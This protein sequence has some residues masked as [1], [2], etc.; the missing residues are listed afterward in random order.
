MT[1]HPLFLDV[2]VPMYAGGKEHPLRPACV[3]V[4]RQA[5]EGMLEVVID[6]EIVQEILH[7]YGAIGEGDIGVKMAR[8]LLDIVP[9]IYAITI[10]DIRLTIEIFEKYVGQGITARDAI[11][12]A[13]MVNNGSTH[14]LSADEH[15]DCVEGI[16]R[17]RVES[18]E[19]T[20]R[21][22]ERLRT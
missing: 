15:F 14:I 10:Q 12:A 7:R 1:G 20:K 22:I 16:T 3:W 6:T 11:H 13:A 19:Q 8:S 21:N 2:N 5:A 4:M 18:L 17:V 9:T